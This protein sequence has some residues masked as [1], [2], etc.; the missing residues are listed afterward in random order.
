MAC[1][2]GAWRPRKGPTRKRTHRIRRCVVPLTGCGRDK[3]QDQGSCFLALR[4]LFP[5]VYVICSLIS[6]SHCKGPVCYLER[7]RATSAHR[8]RTEA[9]KL[10]WRFRNSSKLTTPLMLFQK[11]AASIITRSCFLAMFCVLS[12]VDKH[13]SFCMLQSTSFKVCNYRL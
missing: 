10:Q 9:E 1:T 8:R 6:G 13:S 2:V 12:A 5:T 4:R 3:L 11:A 7:F